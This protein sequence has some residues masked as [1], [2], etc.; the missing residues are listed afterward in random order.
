MVIMSRSQATG[1]VREQGSLS[2]K[3]SLIIIVTVLIILVLQGD[4][5][6]DNK[7]LKQPIVINLMFFVFLS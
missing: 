2:G 1:E 7:N 5:L 4:D 6:Q 3:R